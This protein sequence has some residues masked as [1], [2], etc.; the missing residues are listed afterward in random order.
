MRSFTV[1]YSFSHATTTNKQTF[2]R[3]AKWQL[4]AKE[5]VAKELDGTDE[6]GR[7]RH[8]ERESATQLKGLLTLRGWHGGGGGSAHS[9]SYCTCVTRLNAFQLVGIPH[10]ADLHPLPSLVTTHHPLT[11]HA[12]NPMTQAACRT[13]AICFKT[14]TYTHVQYIHT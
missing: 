10:A 11:T 8:T 12:S 1:C 14:H 6:S 3:A 13:A 7:Q 2:D 5:S 9:L 4:T